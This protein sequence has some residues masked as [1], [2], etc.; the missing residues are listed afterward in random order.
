M[1]CSVH[2]CDHDKMPSYRFCYYH[3]MQMKSFLRRS[4]KEEHRL[5]N[6]IMAPHIDAMNFAMNKAEMRE[7][8]EAD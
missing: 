1:K 7:T 4:Y 5:N 8:N 3:T 6:E 2:G